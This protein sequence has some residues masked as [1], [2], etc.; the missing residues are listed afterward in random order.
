MERKCQQPHSGFYVPLPG[1]ETLH[2]YSFFFFAQNGC[3]EHQKRLEGESRRN[4]EERN[5][6][7]FGKSLT[8]TFS[9]YLVGPKLSLGFSIVETRERMFGPTQCLLWASTVLLQISAVGSLVH[10]FSASFLCVNLGSSREPWIS[11]VR[12]CGDLQMQSLRTHQGSPIWTVSSGDPGLADLLGVL[13][14]EHRAGPAGPH[15]A[16]PCVSQPHLILHPI[17]KSSYGFTPSFYSG[18]WSNVT[19]SERASLLSK[20]MPTQCSSPHL[21]DFCSWYLVV[22]NTIIHVIA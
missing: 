18:L 22:P 4:P 19:S 20:I 10:Q 3:L 9:F 16:P 1:R 13:H 2:F 5:R 11:A 21:L 8:T 12:A 17:P 14:V 7:Y 6:K 15:Q